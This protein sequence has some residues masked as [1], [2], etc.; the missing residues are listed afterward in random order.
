MPLLKAFS[1]KTTMKKIETISQLR[2]EIARMQ[3]VAKQQEQII[4]NDL[5]EIREDLRPENIFWNAFSS[6]TGI[7]MS[8]VEFFKDGIAFGLSLILQRFVLKTEKKL[9]NKVY[10]FVDSLF[11]RVKNMVNKFTG[12]EAKRSER[13]EAEEDVVRGE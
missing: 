9:E 5:K 7:K 13:K 8:K 4:K 1:K 11:E 12:S 6:F 2:G 3:I 10:D